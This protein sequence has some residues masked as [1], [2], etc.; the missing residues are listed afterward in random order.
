MHVA[1]NGAR[2]FVYTID[3]RV[4]GI[5]EARTILALH[6][7]L[8]WDH[9]YL[10]PWLAALAVGRRVVIPDLRGSGRSEQPKYWSSIS[11]DTWTADLEAL[12]ETL[13]L[14]KVVLFGHGFGSFVALECALRFPESLAGLV[15]CSTAPASDYLPVALGLAKQRSTD[16]QFTAATQMLS[17]AVESDEQLTMI[18]EKI[19]PI[20]LYE[21]GALLSDTILHDVLFRAAALRHSL[22]PILTEFDV[23]DRLHHIRAPTLVLAGSADWIAPAHE[24]GE[25]VHAGIPGSRFE[26]FERSGHFPFAEESERFRRVMLDW[27]AE[28]LQGT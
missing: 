13:S 3:G 8:G 21:A 15:L 24:G 6:G 11:F 25:R 4:P 2:H 7:G 5:P 12:R 19:A 17:G 27:M 1:A 23:S 22:G 20:Y 18:M 9:A 26:R 28:A 10:V 14:G 16:D